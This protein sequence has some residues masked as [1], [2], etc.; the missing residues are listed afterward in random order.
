MENKLNQR[1]AFV[2]IN[3]RPRY[4]LSVYRPILATAVDS[5]LPIFTPFPK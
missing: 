2:E 3:N 4:Q 1:G 5:V